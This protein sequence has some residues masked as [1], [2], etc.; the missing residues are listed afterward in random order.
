MIWYVLLDPIKWALCWILN[1]DGFRDQVRRSSSSPGPRPALRPARNRPSPVSHAALRPPSSQPAWRRQTKRASLQ[2][3]SV[4]EQ[5]VVG[6][7]GL[8]GATHSNPLGR[9]SM[10]KPV[11]AVLDR[12]S[13]AVVAVKR[14]ST[15]SAAVANDPNRA[16]GIARRSAVLKAQQNAQQAA[17][18]GSAAA[19]AAAAGSSAELAE[20][21]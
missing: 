11:A 17:S 13:A 7:A 4:K 18:G 15:G 12:T 5:E 14:D 9:A 1:E 21:K 10:S 6:P 19:A 2:R 3:N 8:V 16:M 20:K